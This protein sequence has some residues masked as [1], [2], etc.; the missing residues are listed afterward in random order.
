[1]ENNNTQNNPMMS[2]IGKKKNNSLIIIIVILVLVII[3][4]LVY[5][6]MN[7]PIVETLS[8]SDKQLNQAVASDSTASIKANLNNIN[9]DDTSS[10][11]LKDIDKELQKL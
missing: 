3:A 6:N 5:K 11:D 1:M 8:E 7:K 10:A 2:N 4:S 9:V